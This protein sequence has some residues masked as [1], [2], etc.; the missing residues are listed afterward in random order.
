[1]AGKTLVRMHTWHWDWAQVP[2]RPWRIRSPGQAW[3][4]GC[5]GLWENGRLPRSSSERFLTKHDC[6]GSESVRS[7]TRGKK[8]SE[9]LGSSCA[10]R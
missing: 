3:F 7:G 8:R 5:P 9:V 1:M 10:A 6:P 4:W 2:S